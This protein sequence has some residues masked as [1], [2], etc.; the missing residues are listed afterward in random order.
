MENIWFKNLVV[1]KIKK[2]GFNAAELE[3]ILAQHP[4]QPCADGASESV[5]WLQPKSKNDPFVHC[6]GQHMLI[7]MGTE[8]KILPSS[9]VKQEMANRIE[10]MEQQT[11]CKVGRKESKEI[12]EAVEHELLHKAFSV[13][14]RTLCWI[15]PVGGWLVVNASTASKGDMVL[16]ALRKLFDVNQLVLELV[17]T[18]ISP[19]AAMTNWLNFFDED[20]P[21]IPPEFTVDRDCELRG[22]DEEKPTIR[23]AHLPL[24]SDDIPAHLA[25]GKK[26]TK[27]AITWQSKISFVLTDEFIL[28]KITPLD[29]VKEQNDADDMFDGD[30]AI[31]TGELSQLLADLV[32]GLGGLLPEKV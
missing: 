26:V 31:M 25:A 30:F 21:V 32:G 18:E 8:K 14:S 16:D 5:G 17:K 10:A 1:L 19:V 28:K 6:N 7:S 15:D 12:K 2:I 9:V 11:G 20:T 4:L 24:D 23:Y 3:E 27:L 13:R 29:V 22:D